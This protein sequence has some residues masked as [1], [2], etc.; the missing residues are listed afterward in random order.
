MI[1][2]VLFQTFVLVSA[3]GLLFLLFFVWRYRYARGAKSLLLL[4]FSTFIW[5]AFSF[6]DTNSQ[7]VEGKMLLFKLMHFGVMTI[8]PAWLLFS[9]NYTSREGGLRGWPVVPFF[10]FPIAV[11]TILWIPGGSDYYISAA[12]LIQSG[13]FSVLDRHYEPLF[14]ISASHN[15]VLMIIGAFILIR[16][17]MRQAETSKTTMVLILVAIFLPLV[18]DVLSTFELFNLPEKDITPVSFAFSVLLITLG[19]VRY[20]LFMVAPF[21][22]EHIIRSLRDGILVIDTDLRLVEVN[23]AAMRI[24]NVSEGVIGKKIQEVSNIDSLFERLT[25]KG[26]FL[27]VVSA[28]E[29]EDEKYIETELTPLNDEKGYSVGLLISLHDI[30]ERQRMLD[31]IQTEDRLASIGKLT[32]GVAHEINNP[33]AVIKGLAELMM[34]TDIDEEMKNDITII[35]EEVDKVSKVIDNLLTFAREQA[36][37][38]N[39][40]DINAV[41][42]RVIRLMSFGDDHEG[43]EVLT[44]LSPL[45]PAVFGNE[46][47]LR[48][49][50]VNIIANAEDSMRNANGKGKLNVSTG[51]SE[52]NVWIRITD[53]GPGIPIKDI[54]HIF[55]PFF[56]TDDK[57]NSSGLG[58]SI[59]HG[60]IS[61]HGGK[62]EV[63]SAEGKGTTF[64][65]NLPAYAEID[66]F[67]LKNDFAEHA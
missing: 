61:E 66:E 9:I 41:V 54:R 16:R 43:I 65:I 47:Q 52:G 49:V 45:I 33:L 51:E 63:A 55:D 40:V 21:A 5:A 37:E 7:T 38:K 27:L 24:L 18:F 23:L 26:Y 6:F 20:K 62:I 29:S 53:D 1:Y 30:T 58:L 8:P 17:L 12:G 42:T 13:P 57:N 46:M 59:C 19:L 14:W 22:R 15:Y 3:T 31:R 39:R 34:D 32:A 35:N 64:I 2:Y 4:I 44:D 25:S 28:T 56:T 67:S 48:Q 11:M 10:I 60:I 36:G 50:F